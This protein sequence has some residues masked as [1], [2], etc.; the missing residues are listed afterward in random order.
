MGETSKA[1]E[2]SAKLLEAIREIVSETTGTRPQRNPGGAVKG[3]LWNVFFLSL[4][5]ANLSFLVFLI[6]IEWVEGPHWDLLK[7]AIPVVGGSFLV[8]IA[9]WYNDWTLRVCQGTIFRI[10]QVVLIT[11]FFLAL[12]IPWL[13]IHL[14]VE[15]QDAG[16]FVD[17]EIDPRTDFSEAIWLSLKPH[18]FRVKWQLWSQASP[19]YSF[20]LSMWDTARAAFGGPK[21]RFVPRYRVKFTSDTPGIRIRIMPDIKSTF[22]KDFLKHEL[23]THSL[24]ASQDGGLIFFMPAADETEGA[25]QIPFGHYSVIPVKDGCRVGLS[26][27]LIVGPDLANSIQF[28]TLECGK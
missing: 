22:S 6:P 13:P 16:V 23:A 15:P 10:I 28:E 7:E 1:E 3:V 18:S 4:F 5:V 11:I 8:V 27:D 21:P 17:N 25:T 20:R 24:Q 19:E 9:S 14:N 26:K 2:A 12:W